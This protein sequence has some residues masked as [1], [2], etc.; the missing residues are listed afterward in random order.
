MKKYSEA[1]KS[2]IRPFSVK[3]ANTYDDDLSE[4]IFTGLRRIDGIK[5]DEIGV[6][7][8]EEFEDIFKESRDE[9][10]KLES[11]GYIEMN[12]EGLKLTERGIDISNKIMSIFV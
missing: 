4:A 8:R 10:L 2:G 9:L 6:L 12:D 3:N 11:L 7:S 1:I 5:Y